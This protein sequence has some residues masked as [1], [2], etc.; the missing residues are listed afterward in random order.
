MNICLKA[1]KIFHS[2]NLFRTYIITVQT[3]IDQILL[4]ND[5][6]FYWKTEIGHLQR[7]INIKFCLILLYEN[8]CSLIW[9]QEKSE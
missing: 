7:K 4:L 9:M 2:H 5:P 8:P 6:I 3:F 1:Y